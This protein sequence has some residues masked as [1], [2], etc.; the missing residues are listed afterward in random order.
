MRDALPL[1]CRWLPRLTLPV[2]AGMVLGLPS[3]H[4]VPAHPSISSSRMP[5]G[6]GFSGSAASAVELS[7]S[8][9]FVK[10]PWQVGLISYSTTVGQPLPEYYFTLE[11]D[12]GAGASLA[13][14]TFQQIR[15]ADRQFPFALERT[16]AF[17][18][19]PRRE[20]SPV[21]VKAR[22]NDDTRTMTLDF[23]EPIPPGNTVTVSVVPW[24]NPM[25]SDT[26]LFQVEAYPAGPNPVAS[27]VGI[28]TLRI[29]QNTYW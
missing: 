20:G 8:T 19:R 23:P 4:L 26:Y 11:L 15:G 17:L 24:T 29:Y 9:F 2:I 3:P 25:Q 10:A 21:P 1:G 22:F 16:R 28:G 27:P 7:G 5:T 14:F 18:G 12:P 13:G 6:L